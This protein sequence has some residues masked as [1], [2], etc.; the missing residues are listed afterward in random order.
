MPRVIRSASADKVH[1]A[2]DQRHKP[3]RAEE[4]LWS[5]L[6]AS[7]LGLRFRR[8]HPIGDFVLD[9]Y[10]DE[11]RLAIEID[12]PH[13]AP[14]A[15]YDAWRDERL[16]EQGIRVIRIPPEQVEK[17]LGTVLQRITESLTP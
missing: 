3:T 9:F 14:R 15:N 4:L 13:H 5:A 11:V 8:Q 2:R 6:R 17:G 1:F 7:G 10:C 12:G 16:A